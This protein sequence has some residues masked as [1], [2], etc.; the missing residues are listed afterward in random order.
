MSVRRMIKDDKHQTGKNVQALKTLRFRTTHEPRGPS[1]APS[2]PTGKKP[3]TCNQTTQTERKM[4]MKKILALTLALMMILVSCA[5]AF[6]ADDLTITIE[7]TNE[8]QTYKIYKIF[9]AIVAEGRT[10]GGDGISYQLMEGKTLEDND[11]FQVDAAGNVTAKDGI[12]GDSLKTDAFKT[13]ATSYGT[14]LTEKQV[15]GNG[16]DQIITGLSDGYY[17]ITT[18]T[19]T[20]VTVT[21]VGPAVTVQDKNPPTTVDKSIT[22]VA[23][24]SVT[25]KEKALAQVGTVVH[26]DARIPIANGAV[27]YSFKDDMSAGL[28]NNEDVAVYLVEKDAAVADG[29]EDLKAVCGTITYPTTGDYEIVIVFDNAWLKANIGKDIVIV[30]SATVNSNAVIAD[31]SNP[32]TARI[33][34]G[35]TNHPLTNEDEVEVYSAKISVQKYE[36][37]KANGKALEGAGF[38]LKNSAGKYYKLDDGAVTWVDSEDDGDEHFS[39]ATGTVPAFTGLANG[40]YTLVESTVPV[41]FNKAADQNITI[42]ANDYTAANLSQL[43]EVENNSGAELPS[44]GGIGTT[45]F[46]VIG[47]LLVLGAAIILI[48]RRKADSK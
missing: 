46:Y 41:G 18:T 22:G 2:A 11:W 36:G 6:A 27:N 20:L 17:F 24:G 5:V 42:A 33:E 13:W 43:A 15:T 12:D 32:N 48:S 9:D 38:K 8:G 14:E 47:G 28:T 26:Y 4:T 29:A 1:I 39:A 16:S 45:I 40:T 37:A 7:K 35:D 23:D 44:T 10:A 31:A 21:S 30:Y 19:G 3:E 34:W 25:D